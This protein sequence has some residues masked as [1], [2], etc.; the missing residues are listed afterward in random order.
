MQLQCKLNSNQLKGLKHAGL[1]FKST[2]ARALSN[3]LTNPTAVLSQYFLRNLQKSHFLTDSHNKSEIKGANAHSQRTSEANI[4]TL[5]K[6]H[7]EGNFSRCLCLLLYNLLLLILDS[8]NCRIYRAFFS[9]HSVV[10]LYIKTN[11]EVIL[12]KKK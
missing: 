3:T 11:R 4:K 12:K 1:T 9:A 5:Y 7:K 6:L 10:V 8:K 2:R